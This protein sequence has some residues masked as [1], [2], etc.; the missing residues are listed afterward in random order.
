MEALVVTGVIAMLVVTAFALRTDFRVF[1]ILGLSALGAATGARVVGEKSLSNLLAAIG[2]FELVLAVCLAARAL[3]RKSANVTCEPNEDGN[4]AEAQ[5]A[6]RNK[7][8]A[9]S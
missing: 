8:P 1:T 9:R 2:F 3:S 7:T 5:Q 4:L 6:E